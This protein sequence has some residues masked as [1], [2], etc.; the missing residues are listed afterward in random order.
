MKE[1]VVFE[2]GRR[3]KFF[4]IGF[5]CWWVGTVVPSCLVNGFEF[6]SFSRIMFGQI[7]AKQ[8]KITQNKQNNSNK[9]R[10]LFPT[11]RSFKVIS[12]TVRRFLY[13]IP[14]L[15]Q[16]DKGIKLTLVPIS[17]MAFSMVSLPITEGMEKLLW[18]LRLGLASPCGKGILGYHSLLWLSYF[19]VFRTLSH[20][21]LS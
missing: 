1:V 18:P 17:H 7:P 14:N 10:G 4:L 19:V 12:L 11:K 15:S 3:R 8:I 21:Q 20:P 6:F 2:W 13:P 9:T 5:V 16:R